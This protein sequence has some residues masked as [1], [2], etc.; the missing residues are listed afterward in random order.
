[1]HP[2]H[3]RPNVRPGSG[4]AAY[5]DDYEREHGRWRWAVDAVGK[6]FLECGV[7]EAGFAR[8]RG[9]VC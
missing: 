7:L 8:V 2:T 4:G 3:A 5:E 9:E 1:M 6:R